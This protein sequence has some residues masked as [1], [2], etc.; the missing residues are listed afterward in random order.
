MPFKPDV[1]VVGGGPSG[2]AAATALRRGG[3]GHVVVIEREAETGGIP[4]HAQHQGF[5]VRDLKRV[6]SGPAYALRWSELAAEAGAELLTS[7]QVTGWCE[8]GSLE[9]TGPG[10]RELTKPRATVLATGC[11]ERPRSARWIAGTRPQGV[12]T[13][14]MLQQIVYLLHAR[15]GK[16]AIVVGAEHVSF[17]ALATLEHGGAR[18]VAMITEHSRHQSLSAFRLGGRVRFRAPLKTRTALTAILGR[19][20]V[21][22]VE[23]TNVDTGDVEIVECDTV[24]LTADWVPDHELAVLGGIALDPGTRGPAIDASLRTCRPGVFAVG[25]VLHG[26]ETADIAALIGRHVAEGVLAHLHGAEWSNGRVEI[27]CEAPLHWVAPNVIVPSMHA[28]ESPT[29]RG[30]L[31]RAREHLHDVDLEIRQGSLTIDQLHVRRVTPGRS[32]GIDTK[33]AG[34]IDRRRGPVTIRVKRARSR[35]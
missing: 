6:M 31:L 3:A 28:T 22:A 15:V 18:T 20:R 34:R 33:W 13:T 2:L 25:N 35:P 23:L 26:A 27:R 24:I 7:T 21:E 17:S 29:G 32:A 5:G 14:G 10:G 11:R 19:P 16:R 8:D 4:R 12:M 9:T 30:Y 1:A